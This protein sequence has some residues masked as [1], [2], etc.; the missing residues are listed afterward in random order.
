MMLKLIIFGIDEGYQLYVL[1]NQQNN[2]PKRLV[3]E[4]DPNQ[5]V[6]YV[7]EDIL[8]YNA[9][10][11]PPVLSEVKLVENELVIYYY[12]TVPYDT[13]KNTNYK[14]IKPYETTNKL[15][16]NDNRIELS[17]QD[18]QAIHTALGRRQHCHNKPE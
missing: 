2:L 4:I 6:N 17:I 5:L 16:T 8:N 13:L 9:L 10:F 7:F 12:T 11:S 3:V 14:W 15:A 1:L 18:Y